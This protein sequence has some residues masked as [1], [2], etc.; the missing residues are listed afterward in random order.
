[1][2]GCGSTQPVGIDPDEVERGAPGN[3]RRIARDPSKPQLSCRQPFE[4]CIDELLTMMILFGELGPR[5]PGGGTE[6][7]DQR[8]RLSARPCPILLTPAM[9][10]WHRLWGMRRNIECADTHRA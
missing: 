5:Y 1:M 9:Y 6:P 7:G 2:A 10:D 8:H 3:H 4:Q